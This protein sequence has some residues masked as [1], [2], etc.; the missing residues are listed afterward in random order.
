[1]ATPDW[2]AIKDAFDA[3]LAVAPA[4]RQ[5][6]IEAVY[7][8]RPDVA[9]AVRD[10][11]QGHLGA[12]S[13][14]LVPGS[15]ALRAA[16][17]FA[18]GDI[19]AGRFRVVRPIARGAMGEVYE[20]FDQ[21]LRLAVALKAIRPEFLSDPDTVERFRR[22]VLVTRNISHISIC[23]VFD[24]VEHQLP[25]AVDAGAS[26]LPCL[27]MQ[28]LE[29]ESL[30]EWL[31]RKRP[32][33]I[34]EAL[35]LI[36]QIAD[37]LSVLHE[38]GVIHRDLKP[39]N[40][41]LVGEG[42]ERRAVLT[43][44][45]LARP[46]D[47][48]LFETQGPS[49]G[50]A[51]FFMAPEL[52]HGARPSRASDIYALGL[53][54]DELVTE[55]SAF[56][57]ST[58][59]GLLLEKLGEGPEPPGERAPELPRAWLRTIDRC[60]S[61]DPAQRPRSAREVA[62][63]LQ[64]RETWRQ[65]RPLRRRA[66][67]R[68]P[69]RLAGYTIIAGLLLPVSIGVP[70]AT[71]PSVAIAGIENRTGRSELGYLATGTAGELTRRFSGLRALRVVTVPTKGALRRDS[72]GT[73]YLLSGRVETI[74]GGVRL[75]IA[76]TD[77]AT[78]AVVWT[79]AFDGSIDQ[80][81]H[82]GDQLATETVRAIINLPRSQ[83]ART[84]RWLHGLLSRV[85]AASP[86][87][88]R[89]SGT[90]NAAAFDAYLRGRVLYEDRTVPSALKAIEYLRRAIE[91][92][93]QFAA[94]H[95]T[96]ADINAVLMD[97]QYGSHDVLLAEADRYASQAL[98]LDP[99]SAEAALSLAAVRQ[100]QWRWR[101]SDAAYRRAIELNPTSPRAQRWYGGLLLQFSRFDEGL[102][103]YRRALELDPFDY[104]SQS[105]M[106]HAL[107][108]AGR[109]R[110]AATQLERTIAQR[111]LYYARVLLGQVY[112]YLIADDPAQARLHLRKALEQSDVLRLR[113]GETGSSSAASQYAD[114][115]A[116]L[117]WSYAGN[118]E[119]AHPFVESLETGRSAGHVPAAIVA[120]VY[121]AQG[122]VQESVRALLEAEAIHDRE[123]LYVNVTPIYRPLRG[124]P[125]F[126]N[127]VR[128][129]HLTN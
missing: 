9:R 122:R 109:A 129:L 65:W 34:A 68:R 59:H 39:A 114:M 98:A 7:G 4:D 26:T 42:L 72:A 121:A 43:D 112:A 37:A 41:V 120:R 116:A 36:S 1:M 53:L 85:A 126:E 47:P 86:P 110:D 69:A 27:T 88:P 49:H 45:G 95:A 102:E 70:S 91:L 107:F 127:L 44:F 76:I 61:Q 13:G 115:I 105:A 17:A 48:G 71:A 83:A 31:R 81:M 18:P 124:D 75:T 32:V 57:S 123:L 35:P 14:F 94:P 113:A 15:I 100:M 11:L 108:T 92:D 58:L 96:L 3:V 77:A 80:A 101:E 125:G 62:G 6:H 19:V 24:L 118:R 93:P 82:L 38:S 33:P 84:E 12:S 8:A 74:A 5:A 25:P 119:R 64:A 67:A 128:R 55:R 50:G 103:R 2:E 89:T 10:L 51:P 111:D 97:L 21:R 66:P 46:L 106:G 56:R 20:V 29:G 90:G 23:R 99:E 40:V 22:E 73:T 79:K 28:L 52:F 60:L 87:R 16:W 117:A 78:D 63:G 54:A 30:E 104:P